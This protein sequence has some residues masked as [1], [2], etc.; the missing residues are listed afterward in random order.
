MELKDYIG[1]IKRRFILLILVFCVIMASVFAYATFLDKQTY[2]AFGT[3]SIGGRVTTDPTQRVFQ[4][5]SINTATELERIGSDDTITH[6]KSFLPVVFLA[7]KINETLNPNSAKTTEQY[8]KDKA[9][10]LANANRALREFNP[11]RTEVFRIEDDVNTSLVPFTGSNPKL[12]FNTYYVPSNPADRG[13]D[14]PDLYDLRNRLLGVKYFVAEDK[15]DFALHLISLYPE[16]ANPEWN[17]M[18][19]NIPDPSAI[20]INRPGFSPKGETKFVDFELQTYD[21]QEAWLHVW[22]FIYGATYA[23]WIRTSK[24]LVTE[25]TEG[26]KQI[27]DIRESIKK[28]ELLLTTLRQK[29]GLTSDEAPRRQIDRAVTTSARE[30]NDLEDLIEANNENQ[31]RIQH[32]IQELDSYVRFLDVSDFGRVANSTTESL[33]QGNKPITD[34]RNEM[35]SLTNQDEELATRMTPIHPDRQSI[36]RRLTALRENLNQQERLA[37]ENQRTKL[38]RDL[39]FAKMEGDRLSERLNRDYDKDAAIPWRILGE[40]EGGMGGKSSLEVF[41]DSM[42]SREANTNSFDAFVNEF[43]REDLGREVVDDRIINET[44]MQRSTEPGGPQAAEA[45]WNHRRTQFNRIEVLYASL[46][47]ELAELVARQ[48]TVSESAQRAVER[49]GSNFGQ[50]FPEVGENAAALMLSSFVR[51]VPKR[52]EDIWMLSFLLALFIGIITIALAEY[53]DTQIKTEYDV[54]KYLNLPVLTIIPN[55]KKEILL[56]DAPLK[57]PM[58]ERYNIAATLIRSTAK[59]LSLRSFVV[60]SAIPKEGKTTVSINLSVALSRKGMKVCLVDSDLRAPQ[61]HNIFGLQNFQGLT[62]ILKRESKEEG[63]SDHRSGYA[64][65]LNKDTDI[66]NLHIITSG[67]VPDDPVVLLESEAMKQLV[68]E[69]M[70]DYDAVLF[71][72]PPVGMIGDTLIISQYCDANI[73]VVGAQVVDQAEVTHAKRMLSS[74]HANILGVILNKSVEKKN[75][76]YYYYY[77]SESRR[78]GQIR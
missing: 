23:D 67:P 43:V 59:E 37:I 14:F 26:R 8:E 31:S 24:G 49:M 62:T 55:E 73:F 42:L 6:A 51:A 45:L 40:Q 25:R 5:R 28:R 56:T 7:S 16:E 11:K 71:D 66:E 44:A 3:M 36:H 10:L 69:L 41:V 27:N 48:A 76:E 64:K 54:R 70:D 34:I 21:A 38:S 12:D 78:V 29:F 65:V 53:L 35:R 46:E 18:Y 50:Y 68:Q 32:Q 52:T 9:D 15:R 22:A 39:S 19:R 57:S 72:T 74:V 75:K 2:R 4:D 13:N 1:I 60:S 20:K 63:D 77:S 17:Y 33:F 30:K 61:M 47:R 58:A